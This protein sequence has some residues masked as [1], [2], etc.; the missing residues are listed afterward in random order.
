[1]KLCTLF[2]VLY[3]VNQSVFAQ[4]T[5][6]VSGLQPYSALQNYQ[7]GLEL[8]ERNRM[9][10]AIPY[11][12]EAVRRCMDEISSNTAGSESY[13]ILAWTLARQER[14][15]EVI[16][17]GEHGLRTNTDYRLIETMGEAYFYLKDYERA[18]SFMQRYVNA[19]P[20]GSATAT[21]YFFVGEIY[22]LN[23]RFL[24]ADIAYTTAVKLNP[25]NSSWWYHLG[26]SREAAGERVQ[27]IKAYEQA[28][29]LNPRNQQARDALERV[30]RG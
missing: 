19:V 15:S 27:A 2:F 9:N 26:L 28:V 25:H 12:N 29:N 1:M 8:E 3:L 16:Q 30:S 7:I 13:V 10:E 22:H 14:Y 21:A 20:Q 11:Y 4:I 24:H 23:R 17:W 18:L 6:S 5:G